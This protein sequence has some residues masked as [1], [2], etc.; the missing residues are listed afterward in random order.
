MIILLSIVIINYANHFPID[1]LC[2]KEGNTMSNFKEIWQTLASINCTEKIAKK[3]NLS[4]LSW[5]WAWGELM[6][7]YP[8]AE[9]SFDPPVT[10]PD[11]S[12]E[13]WC[14]VSIDSCKRKIWLPV[15]DHTNKSVINPSSRKISD[16]RMRCLTKCLAMFGLGHYIY[17]G[18]DIPDPEVEKIRISEE[19]LEDY[20]DLCADYQAS[21][22]A[23]K[24][25]IA[26]NNFSSACEAW[27]ELSEDV[28]IALWR[29]PSKGGCFTTK[30]RE[31]MKSKEFRESFNYENK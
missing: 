25:G 18:E 7:H 10:L 19:A 15:M 13:I 20:K 5:T 8:Q 3:G 4:Y 17:A 11:G 23:I 30:E 26:E 29:A 6:K 27:Q 28:K 21:I 9:Y 24:L 22:D 16:T 14:E 1:I 2:K 31:I 12:V